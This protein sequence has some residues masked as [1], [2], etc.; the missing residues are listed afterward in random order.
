MYIYMYV[1]SGRTF[2]R[3]WC[4][5]KQER[6]RSDP[7][8]AVSFTY[9]V[10]QIKLKSIMSTFLFDFLSASSRDESGFGP[11]L[12]NH[13]KLDSPQE[14]QPII[15]WLC[16][17]AW[18]SE[19]VCIVVFSLAFHSPQPYTDAP[20]STCPLELYILLSWRVLEAVTTLCV[21]KFG[22]C[23]VMPKLSVRPVSL[24][25]LI[26]AEREGYELWYIYIYINIYI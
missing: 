17:A 16:H 2:W 18:F 25:L 12:W 26:V 24:F 11:Y 9:I 5:S 15:C 13:C 8:E 1:F 19:V 7:C 23:S 4:D 21:S 3:F 20:P 10:L 6:G 14:S 22:R